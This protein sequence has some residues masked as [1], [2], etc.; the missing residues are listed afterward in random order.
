MKIFKQI[1]KSS[2]SKGLAA[3]LI[4]NMLGEII[5][6]TVSLAL[7][8]GPSQPEI[9]SFEPV[10]TTDMVNLFTGDFTYNIPLLYLPGP[11]GGYP[12]NIAYHGGITMDQEASW[13]G[14][15]W[16]IN[17]GAI[18]RS[19]RGLPDDFNGDIVKTTTDIKNNYTIGVGLSGNSEGFGADA[20]IH[21]G[22]RLTI[23]YNNYKGFG[24]S[25]DAG[26]N[27]GNTTPGY[28]VGLSISDED[29][30]G[31]NADLTLSGEIKKHDLKGSLGVGLSSKTGLTLTLKSKIN[32]KTTE[33]SHENE[34]GLMIVDY[35]GYKSYRGKSSITFSSSSHAP[36]ISMPMYNT[37][38]KVGL[39]LGTETNVGIFYNLY[40]NGFFNITKLKDKNKKIDNNAFGYENLSNYTNN[41]NIIG[42]FSRTQDGNVMKAT[43]NL[44]TPQITHDF[45]QILGQGIGGVFRAY[46]TDVGAIYDP[47][48]STTT[49]GGSV[50]FKIGAGANA[51]KFGGS[52][53]LTFGVNKQ[54]RWTYNNE[55]LDLSFSPN[56]SIIENSISTA[57]LTIV[58]EQIYY[59]SH[60]ESTS[61]SE[62]ELNYIGGESAI[63]GD[64]AGNGFFGNY[65]VLDIVGVNNERNIADRIPRNNLIHKLKNK[66]INNFHI[67]GNDLIRSDISDNVD[68]NHYIQEYE[69][70]YYKWG[71]NNN[72]YQSEPTNYLS[73]KTHPNHNAGYKVLDQSGSYYVYGLPTY[74]TKKLEEI[75]TVNGSN[76]WATC[77]NT[78]DIP[79]DDEQK[80]DYKQLNT[81]KYHR[82]IETPAY[83][84]SYLLTSIL[85]ADYID[86]DNNGPSNNDYGYWVKMSYVKYAGGDSPYKWRAPFNEAMYMK[87]S[88]STLEDDKG[89][90]QYGEKEMWYMNKMETKTHILIYELSE[91]RDNFEANKQYN[92]NNEIGTLSG[93]KINKIHLYEKKEYLEKGDLATPIQTVHFVYDYSLCKNVLNN[94]GVAENNEHVLSNENGKLTLKEIYITTEGNT[95]GMLTPYK[96]NYDDL[97]I[98][99][100][101][102]NPDYDL[103]KYDRWGNYK[104]DNVSPCAQVDLPYTEQFDRG[105]IQTDTEKEIFNNNQNHRIGAWSLKEITLPSGG[106]I[107]VDYEKDD[108]AYVQSERATQM[109]YMSKLNDNTSDNNVLYNPKSDPAGNNFATDY[110]Q[111]RI[112]FKLEHRIQQDA[113]RS[114]EDYA[115]EI[116]NDYVKDIIKDEGGK[117]NLYFKNYTSLKDEAADYVSGY[118]PLEQNAYITGADGNVNLFYGVSDLSGGYYNEGYVTIEC[119]NKKNGDC[120]DK[121]HPMALAAWQTTRINNSEL[122]G[123]T[124]DSFD[125]S[126]VMTNKQK[127]TKVKNLLGFLPEIAQVFQG[128]RHWCYKKEMAKTIDLNRSVIKLTSPDKKKIGGGLRVKKI[129]L[130]DNWDQFQTQENA[131]TYGLEY[132]YE[133]IENGKRISSGVAQY[134]PMIGGDENPLRY[135]KF[136]T[137]NIPF[138]TDNNLFHERPINES[139]MPAPMV[140]YSKVIVSSIETAKQIK[141]AENL[142]SDI[143]RGVTGVQQY[144]FYTAKDFPVIVKET[145]IQKKSFNV[146]III[147]FIGA[148][149]RNKLAA[150]QGY[151]IELNDMHGKTKSISSYGLNPLDYSVN[152]TPISSTKMNYQSKYF[153]YHHKSVRRLVNKVKTMAQFNGTIEDRLIGVESEFFTDQRHT[154]NWSISAGLIFNVD[155]IAVL[156]IPITVPSLW[157]SI[158]SNKN[159]LKTFVTNKIIHKA[160][161][162]ISTETTNESYVSTSRNVLFD[163]ISGRPILTKVNNEYNN[164]IYSFNH[165]AHWEYDGMGHAYKNINIEFSADIVSVSTSNNLYSC[166]LP[167]SILNSKLSPGDVFIIRKGDDITSK[168]YKATFISRNE[169]NTTE[170][171]FYIEFPKNGLIPDISVAWA[172]KLYKSGRKNHFMQDVGNLTL[173]G[174]V[175]STIPTNPISGGLTADNQ[176]MGNNLSISANKINTGV[177]SATAVTFRDNWESIYGLPNIVDSEK[178]ENPYATGEQGIWRMH[179]SYV[180]IGDRKQSDDGVGGKQVNL[181]QDGIMENV[182]M[183]NWQVLDF[184][185]YDSKWFASGEVSKYNKF[186]YE[187]ENINKL[188][189]YSSALYGYNNA[190]VI[191]VGANSNYYE[192]GVE[193]FERFKVGQDNDV[194]EMSKESNLNF[195]NAPSSQPIVNFSNNYKIVEG[196]VDALNLNVLVDMSASYD[197]ADP[198]LTQIDFSLYGSNKSRLFSRNI[199]DLTIDN[200]SYPGKVLLSIPK[201]NI[202]PSTVNQALSY[203]NDGQVGG[204]ITIYKTKNSVAYPA[205]IPSVEFTSVFAHT[206]KNSMKVSGNASFYHPNIELEAGKTY[207]FSCWIR[208]DNSNVSTYTGY[209]INFTEFPEAAIPQVIT[210]VGKI[211]E[212]W[213]KVEI[214]M[215]SNGS[216]YVYTQF[217]TSA[218]NSPIYVDD[219]RI[220]PKTGGMTSYVYDPINFRLKATLDANNYATF[221]YYDEQGNLHLTKQETE[222]GV[223]TITENHSYSK[224]T[225]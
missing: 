172:F 220:S 96:F 218:G 120:F 50:M 74:N 34:D 13:V 217:I 159:D 70:F 132:T 12:I 95:R 65:K 189:V 188:G 146:P 110:T 176:I 213:Q 68:H 84:T 77:N 149:R 44:A 28:N 86:V 204:Q 99:N 67:N 153:I 72:N 49:Q 46:R 216:Q 51:L 17:A 148:Y 39:K 167:A 124:G 197:W 111:R 63:T 59:K 94:D 9:Q 14:L 199:N 196:F 62:Y 37:Y 109:F 223:F 150:S 66:E 23:Q 178:N 40:V 80:V 138:K 163:K 97:N 194:N 43:A 2:F 161:I 82:L 168:N 73:R 221:Y 19:V 101:D 143:G 7:T 32:K 135:P 60:G 185:K 170:G 116:F 225:N 133:T 191:G 137:G 108:Y 56:E 113:S 200:T 118:V 83:A 156:P 211:V 187:I 140:G 171:I 42:D 125:E 139:Y 169:S 33:S 207:I 8:S 16:N 202:N 186:G 92:T 136:Y 54:K 105:N 61:I 141:K 4:I 210:R 81:H 126:N 180:Y 144:E 193:D 183:F 85:G 91:R 112:Y 24:Y 29:G 103:Y 11:N 36:N 104:V 45:Y 3:F 38:L 20:N 214:E 58:D 21:L 121:Y 192:I 152:A 115:Q 158:E 127:A 155:V 1:R 147:P 88:V 90:Y 87:G 201:S 71:E 209:D 10:E 175:N 164:P 215:T 75:F 26:L 89:T 6:P 173:L 76:N 22:G 129:V 128:Y 190:F 55:N 53:G 198:D 182:T 219:V 130:S 145:E 30:V 114:D 151:K 57:G 212:G 123:S 122:L 107:H 166:V 177:L 205:T 131:E 93:L 224:P 78:V 52:A 35:T 106:T 179:K 64:I 98:P 5:A 117:I 79:L 100:I 25:L 203:L 31:V 18:D 119:T 15:G 102:E 69:I 222:E 154:K 142:T 184:E 162:L 47:Y 174:A 165:P 41:S 157:G 160:G 195:Y 27:N 208:K 134:E 48:T 206:G 181:S